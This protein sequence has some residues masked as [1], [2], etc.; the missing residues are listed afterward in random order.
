MRGQAEERDEKWGATS[1][2]QI[3]GSERWQGS[4]TGKTHV[5]SGDSAETPSLGPLIHSFQ[6]SQFCN[7]SFDTTPDPRSVI[8]SACSEGIRSARMER[9]GSMGGLAV[10][11]EALILEKG[12]IN[13]SDND[14]M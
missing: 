13:D 10:D 14:F 6:T 3:W 12:R 11:L 7:R 4:L 1:D 2:L 5:I 9:E 8:G